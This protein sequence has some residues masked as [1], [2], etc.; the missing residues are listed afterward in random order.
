MATIRK[1]ILRRVLLLAGLLITLGLFLGGSF[2]QPSQIQSQ[3]K[4]VT[5]D[6]VLEKELRMQLHKQLQSEVDADVESK[7]K[8]AEKNTGKLDTTNGHLQ[9]EHAEVSAKNHVEESESEGESIAAVDN[10]GYTTEDW[11]A[12]NAVSISNF[13]E[14]DHKVQS[15]FKH[16][17]KVLAKNQCSY[18]LERRMKLE[19]GKPIIDNVLFI[20]SEEELLSESRLFGYFDF[21]D[22]FVQDL[23]EKHRIV[24]SSIP[25]MQPKF[26]K[27]DGYAIVGGG[28]YSWLAF[29]GIMSLREVGASLP[30][31][32]IIPTQDDYEEYFCE[33]LLPTVNAR[34]VQLE[35]VFGSLSLRRLKFTGYQLK[36]LAL[37]ASSFEN[38]FLLDSDSY[39]V[40]NPEPLFTSD[41][42]KKYKMITWP[43]F[44]RR[45]TSPVYYQIADLDYTGKPVRFINDIFTD[46]EISASKKT[47]G[48]IDPSNDYNLHDLRNTM[49]DWSTE[50]GEMLINKK[51]HFKTLL[52]ALYYNYDG[53]YCYH[54]LLSQGGAGEGDKETF[55]AAASYYHL[56]IY[57]VYKRPDRAHGF[58]NKLDEWDHTTIIQYDPI[59]D[60]ENL[61]KIKESI[62]HDMGDLETFDYNYPKYFYEGGKISD[63]I[64]MF[65]HCHDPKFDPVSILLKKQTMVRKNMKL[66]K[67]RRRIFGEDFP[68]GSIDLELSLWQIADKY[69]CRKKTPFVAFEGSDMDEF[70]N[71]ELPPQLEFLEKSHNYLIEQYNPNNPYE[72]LNGANDI[73]LKMFKSGSAAKAEV[74]A[75]KKE[76]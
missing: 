62:E 36:S 11:D 59:T 54:P 38:V 31:E 51:V 37:L 61:L 34:C 5:P 69:L 19:N 47:D 72:Q 7:V 74:G 56:P 67:R 50:S 76:L 6:A 1:S 39:A 55:V 71:V 21:P 41:L 3:G 63:S 14:G 25:K 15:F 58:Y 26:Y 22:N 27:G 4:V 64:P 23:H 20:D 48:E 43:D 29:A 73:E 44:W 8:L 30:V 75:V 60:Y 42:Y 33:E 2:S 9:Q 16:Y 46:P 70:C 53:P 45:T 10:Y 49:M 24:A 17:F 57:Q 32:V 52:L 40:T 28:K 65:Y 68:R 66:L 13:L 35:K 18:P 12:L